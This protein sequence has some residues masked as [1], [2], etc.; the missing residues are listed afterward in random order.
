MSKSTNTQSE[1]DT[2]STDSAGASPSVACITWASR[3]IGLELARLHAQQGHTL[4]LIARNE[5]DLQRIAKEFARTYSICVHILPLD[6]TQTDADKIV[7]EFCQENDLTVDYL[8]NNAWFW[9][10]GAFA[11]REREQDSA[12]IDLNIKALTALT[13]RFVPDMVARGSWKIL[14]VASTAWMVP[15]PMQ[16]VYHATKAYVLSLSQAVASELEGTWVTM[17]ALCPG[18]VDTNFAHVADLEDTTVF[19]D[20]ASPSDVA[21]DGFDAMQQG[22]LVVISWL[23]GYYKLLIGMLPLLPRRVVLNQAKKAIAKTK[24]KN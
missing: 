17:T 6:L 15:G 10:Y 23:S 19:Q 18:P 9:W 16:A 20:P 2:R 3:W 21:Q 24:K 11:Q 7:W 12:M 1:N 8:V 4:V 5:D 14:Q 13:H 22:K